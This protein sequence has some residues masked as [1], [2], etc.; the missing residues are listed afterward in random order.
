[1]SGT[2]GIVAAR[3]LFKK[4]AQVLGAAAIEDSGGPF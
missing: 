1:M 3:Q 4:R 2:I